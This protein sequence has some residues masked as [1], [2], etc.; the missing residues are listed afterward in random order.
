MYQNIASYLP[1]DVA[2]IFSNKSQQIAKSKHKGRVK[3]HL[4]KGDR[5]KKV[6]W[7]EFVDKMHQDIQEALD[8]GYQFSDLCILL[9]GK[10]EIAATIE[11][12]GNKKVIIKG[13]EVPIP[14]LSK[15]GLRVDVSIS[16]KAII[17]LLY[18][19]QNPLNDIYFS[20]F[21]YYLKQLGHISEETDFTDLLSKYLK[22]NYLEKQQELKQEFNLQFGENEN[23]YN[24]YQQVEYYARELTVNDKETEYMVAFLEVTHEFTQNQNASI[25]QFLEYW[26][27]K[28]NKINIQSS[29]DIQAIRLLTI[30]DSKGLEFPIVFLPIQKAN[31]DTKINAWFDVPTNWLNIE[32]IPLKSFY[33]NTTQNKTVPLIEKYDPVWAQF[34]E[35]EANKNLNDRFCLYYVATTRAE[36]QLHLYVEGDVENRKENDNE[37]FD[38]LIENFYQ[39]ESS[40]DLFDNMQLDNK[41]PIQPLASKQDKTDQRLQHAFAKRTSNEQVVKIANPS[42]KYQVNKESVRL[43]I[44]IHEILEKLRSKKQ[45]PGLLESYHLQGLIAQKDLSSI[46]NRIEH[47]IND[48]RYS[49]F[50]EEDS[51]VQ[52]EREIAIKIDGEIILFRPDRLMKTGEGWV[53]IDYKTGE[54][55]PEHERQLMYYQNNLEQLGEKV[56]SSHLIY[57]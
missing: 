12:L 55:K 15:E 19:Q 57:L 2:N 54:Q 13:Q 24:L 20:N 47:I 56:A 5:A 30:H 7:D 32:N 25:P 29:S 46:K 44:L 17:S 3:A 43:G 40:F 27:E 9:R 18:W 48:P 52:N 38:Y 16:V 42:L 35:Q 53:I 23:A 22:L 11:A 49:T 28:S 45:L 21:F 41:K 34:L 31:Y 4:L 37:I 8:N 33:Y 26:E 6:F 10:K 39:G 36:H 51:Q 14:Y 1:I 50:F